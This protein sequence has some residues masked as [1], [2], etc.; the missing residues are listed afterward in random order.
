MGQIC[1]VKPSSLTSKSVEKDKMEGLAL[2][3]MKKLAEKFSRGEVDEDKLFVVRDELLGAVGLEPPPRGR[4]FP[5]GKKKASGK[6]S[7]K[8]PAPMKRPA[9]AVQSASPQKPAKKKSAVVETDPPKKQEAPKTSLAV[10]AGTARIRQDDVMG[11]PPD[12]ELDVF[13]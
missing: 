6:T 7:G 11:L 5:A 13:W 3:V 1:Q 8:P 2:E 12:D 9:A 10:S 4:L